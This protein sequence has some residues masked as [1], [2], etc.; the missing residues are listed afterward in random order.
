M[1]RCGLLALVLSALLAAP[2]SALADKSFTISQAAV[3]VTLARTGEVLVREDLTFSFDGFFTGAYRDIPL[4]GD[5]TA[6]DVELSEGGAR[7]APGGDTALGSSDA[8]GRFG[9]VRMPKGLRIVWHYRQDGGLRTFTLR[10]RLRGV[11]V[12]HD[13]AVEVA[14]QVWGRQWQFG[15]RSLTANVRAAGGLPGTR[16]WIE[17]AWLHHRLSVSRGAAQAAV[18][19]VPAQH[20]VTLR[21][22]YP[23]AALAPGA[24]YAR[25]VHDDILPAT[26]AREQRAEARAGRDRRQLED[27]L[28]H[29]W[30]WILAAFLLAIV[31]AGLLGSLAY[32]RFGRERPTGTA[33]KYVHEPPDDLA[34]ALVPSLLAQHVVAGGDQMAATLFELVRRGRYKMTPVTREEST[35]LGLHHKEIDDVD[36]TRGDQSVELNAVEKPIAAIFDKLTQDGATALSRV[37]STVRSMP[38]SDRE[39]FHG[40]SEAFASAVESQARRRSFWSGRGMVM[41]WLAFVVFLLLGAAFLVAGIAGLADPPLVRQDLILTAIGAALALNAAV[42]LLLRASVWRRRGPELQASAEGWEAFRRYLSDFPRLADK[43]ADTLPL[44]ESY[45]VYGI[46]FGIA[47]RVL[48]AA[49]VDFPGISSSAV[50]APAL[51]VSSF[52]TGSFASGLGGAFGSPSSGGSGGGGGGGSFGGGGGGAW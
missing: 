52:N 30:A 21:V 1:K 48:A 10:Y 7:Y 16:A 46:T 23:P 6:Q 32:W 17:P 24:P 4:A 3:G 19:D 18:D 37:Q 15:L 43:P 31:P 45:L 5:V 36:L 13:D 28:H 42:V 11:V 9:F 47:E 35:L 27:T 33:A 38:T 41:K 22:L 50:Y 44:W 51:A 14:P 29:P 26:I 49:K 39:W 8:P 12:A 2:A 34:P 40:R 20:S 25:H